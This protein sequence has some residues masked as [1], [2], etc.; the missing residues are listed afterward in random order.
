VSSYTSG[1]LPPPTCSQRIVA[2]PFS[3]SLK[4]FH[5]VT[6]EVSVAVSSARR[7]PSS[8]REI[9][10]WAHTIGGKAIWKQ[11]GMITE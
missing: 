4:R 6:A 8:A 2:F 1:A 5:S 10:S 11:L 7:V 3:N 9:L